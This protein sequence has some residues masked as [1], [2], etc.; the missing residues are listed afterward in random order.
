MGGM[1]KSS[2]GGQRGNI[3]SASGRKE[4]SPTSRSQ[5]GSRV[6]P[7]HTSGKKQ[8]TAAKTAAKKAAGKKKG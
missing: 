1:S 3:T 4:R 2:G 7:S 5:S 6:E 8:A